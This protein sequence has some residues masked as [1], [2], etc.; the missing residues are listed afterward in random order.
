MESVLEIL[1]W[2]IIVMIVFYIANT[3]CY[4]RTA[5]SLF[6]SF[7]VASFFIYFIYRSIF[8]EIVL[9]LS[10][11]IGLIYAIFR[12]V[13]DKRDDISVHFIPNANASNAIG[14]R[15]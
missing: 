13:R 10:C 9:M 15:A 14:I 2:A 6:I 11:T 3:A 1:I 12:A 5:G 7:L 4:V 8:G